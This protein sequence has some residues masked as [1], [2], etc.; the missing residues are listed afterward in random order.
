[1]STLAILTKGTDT[2]KLVVTTKSFVT[3]PYIV[4]DLWQFMFK[5]Y[6]HDGDGV[7]ATVEIKNLIKHMAKMAENYVG[8]GQLIIK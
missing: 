8:A 5:F 3:T 2:Q 4:N 6:D 7:L 1:M